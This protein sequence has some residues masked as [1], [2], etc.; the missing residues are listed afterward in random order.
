M[1]SSHI[2]A[3]VGLAIAAFAWNHTR[4]FNQTEIKIV[5]EKG[6]IVVTASPYVSQ[7]TIDKLIKNFEQRVDERPVN[8]KLIAFYH[9]QFGKRISYVS[10]Y[11]A[12]RCGYSFEHFDPTF[13]RRFMDHLTFTQQDEIRGIV[14]EA[15]KMANIH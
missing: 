5:P 4:H 7:P 3:C 2:V 12:D 13:Q 11:D 15:K 1:N 10:S 9:F 6:F 8:K 14:D